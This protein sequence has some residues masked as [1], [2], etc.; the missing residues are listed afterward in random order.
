VKYTKLIPPQDRQ[1]KSAKVG[2]W[3]VLPFGRIHFTFGQPLQIETAG[4]N[5]SLQGAADM[6][7]TKLNLL[8]QSLE[9]ACPG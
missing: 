4:D 6:L 8:E 3:F 7:A 2:G 9:F 5:A 1:T